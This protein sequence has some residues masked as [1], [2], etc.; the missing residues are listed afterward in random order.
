[1]TKEY[2][3]DIIL[4]KEKA[5]SLP[6]IIKEALHL[7]PQDRYIIIENLIKSLDAPDEEIDEIWIEESQKRVKAYKKGLT[8]TLSYN[9]VFNV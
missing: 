3:L 2:F 6:E 4:L 1:V 5:M 9:Q 8:K 7:K